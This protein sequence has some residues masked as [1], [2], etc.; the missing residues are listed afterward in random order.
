MHIVDTASPSATK[1][2]RTRDGKVDLDAYRQI[3][4]KY[5]IDGLDIDVTITDARTRFGHL[6]LLISPTSG[7]GEKW[8]ERKNLEIRQDPADTPVFA[9]H[10]ESPTTGESEAPAY[11]SLEEQVLSIIQK[12]S[13]K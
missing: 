13:V 1:V 11:P 8:V 12:T 4:A 2:A 5:S 6:D 10:S 9:G 3:P 7:S